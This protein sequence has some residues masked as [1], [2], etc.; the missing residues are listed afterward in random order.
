M[1]LLL[2]SAVANYFTVPPVC[3][4]YSDGKKFYS[5]GKTTSSPDN[6]ITSTDVASYNFA[7]AFILCKASAFLFLCIINNNF[8]NPF[9]LKNE[10]ARWKVPSTLEDLTNEVVRVLKSR[11]DIKYVL[12][13][14]A[15]HAVD[16][17][18]TMIHVILIYV[19]SLFCA[20]SMGYSWEEAKYEIF[21]TVK[22]CR[23]SHWPYQV[24]CKI[25]YG[26]VFKV[27]FI[28][29]WS[30][31]LVMS[32][33][34]LCHIVLQFRRYFRIRQKLKNTYFIK[35][36]GWLVEMCEENIY[37][38]D[39]MARSLG[40]RNFEAS[41]RRLVLDPRVNMY[42]TKKFCYNIIAEGSIADNNEMIFA[43]PW[44][45]HPI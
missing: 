8:K 10:A 44:S 40:I 38:L 13:D 35:K 14:G 15:N 23:F 12:I 4:V 45:S 1:W 33:V 29:L 42:A 22:K 31:Y 25:H 20:L 9:L 7:Y 28:I 6:D 5:C 24:Q 30:W 19:F 41:T 27:I 36:E 11:L 26:S 32:L 39:S 17:L 16:I 34:G 37:E 3:K 21:P 43:H 2:I 18:H